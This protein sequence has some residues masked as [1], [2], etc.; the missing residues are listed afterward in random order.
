MGPLVLALVLGAAAAETSAE[1]AARRRSHAAALECPWRVTEAERD[2]DVSSQLAVSIVSADVALGAGADAGLCGDRLVLALPAGLAERAVYLEA[3]QGE[4]DAARNVPLAL[5]APRVRYADGVVAAEYVATLPV[6]VLPGEKTRVEIFAVADGAVTTDAE[7]AAEY[8]DDTAGVLSPYP[9]AAQSSRFRIGAAASLAEPPPT[10]RESKELVYEK[11]GEAVAS[12]AEPL[13]LL[14][15]PASPWPRATTVTRTVDVAHRGPAAVSE[16]YAL[17][18]AGAPY[19]GDSHYSKVDAQ[20]STVVRSLSAVLP[21]GA[22]HVAVRDGL[23]NVTSGR[24]RW[25]SEAA[26]LDFEPRHPLLG[27]WNTTFELTYRVPGAAASASGRTRLPLKFGCPIEDVV[28]DDYELRVVLPEGASDV[29]V[30]A[31]FRQTLKGEVKMADQRP[32]LPWIFGASRPVVIL[33]TSRL[34]YEHSTEFHVEY[35]TSTPHALRLPAAVAFL[36]LVALATVATALRLTV[37]ASDDDT[38]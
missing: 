14:F 23:G 15:P 6:R 5:A 28:V 16:A 4:G 17:T 20:R 37:C 30:E 31:P 8:V 32:Q 25:G 27:G 3:E 13:R 33:R 18:N 38:Q 35:T 1:H 22:S 36:A 34:V 24:V 7:G 10:R 26:T 21:P 29:D 2:T 19:A 11:E 9:V 12:D